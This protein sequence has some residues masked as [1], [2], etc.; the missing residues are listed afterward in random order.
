MYML[1]EQYKKSLILSSEILV[2]PETKQKTYALNSHSDDLPKK[3]GL[4]VLSKVTKYLKSYFDLDPVEIQAKKQEA[5]DDIR[6]QEIISEESEASPDE[7]LEKL[8]EE[9]V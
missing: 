7:I 8:W 3:E 2:D 1:K 5:I 6:I 9:G 4:G